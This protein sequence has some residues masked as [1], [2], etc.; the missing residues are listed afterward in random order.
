MSRF[1]QELTDK[2]VRSRDRY[3]VRNHTDMKKTINSLQQQFLTNSIYACTNIL[4]SEDEGMELYATWNKGR[5]NMSEDYKDSKNSKL[6]SNTIQEEILRRVSSK[7][8]LARA[9]QIQH[10]RTKVPEDL[11]GVYALHIVKEHFP[12]VTLDVLVSDILKVLIF[13]LQ[14][15]R[16]ATFD[17]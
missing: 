8:N 16:C 15:P 12:Q 11:L 1:K 2:I 4:G 7:D 6:Q 14:S 5:S 17:E 10:A 9:L 13:S 3:L